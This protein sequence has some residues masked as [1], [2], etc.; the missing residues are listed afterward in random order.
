MLVNVTSGE[1]SK[2]ENSIIGLNH[3]GGRFPKSGK[4]IPN[5]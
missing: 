4:R 2:G 3:G 1:I 5:V